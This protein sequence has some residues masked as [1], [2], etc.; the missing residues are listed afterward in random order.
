[1]KLALFNDFVPGVVRDDEIINIEALLRPL[2][3]RNPQDL[4][5][6]LIRQWDEYKPL[7]KAHFVN[8]RGVPLS[9][10]R[11][12]AP[13]PRPSK[14]ICAAANYKEGI[15][16][17]VSELDFFHKSPSAIIG[18][19]DT[20]VLPRAQVTIFHHE[21]E[22]G[23]V[24]GKNSKN[25]PTERAMDS[26]FGYTIFQDGSA[27]GIL[28]NGQM[29]F[30]LSKNWDT[31]APIG[32]F[33]VTADEI[34]DPHKLQVRLWVNGE[35]R[36]DYN[37]SDMAHRIPVLIARASE[38]NTLLPGDIIAA[39]CNR[40]GLG[41]MQ[42]GDTMVQEIGGLG[43]LTTPVIDPLKR[44]WPPGIDAE[45]AEFVRKPPA[46]RGKMGPPRIVSPT[47]LAHS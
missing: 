31:F 14:I 40:Q 28:A 23:I 18:D 1:M 39:G 17:N 24:V 46:Q 2:H 38:I 19:G 27:R 7:I 4:M 20:M 33:L 37:T 32:P 25:V 12:R 16:G 11:L 5:E 44:E 45:F 22:L 3:E 47:A 35:L 13:L 26:V 42:D 6:R 8:A 30:F 10:V 21:L 34:P 9:S 41:P 43:R 15:E 29:S 36:Q